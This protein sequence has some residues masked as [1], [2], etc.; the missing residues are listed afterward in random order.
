MRAQTRVA[1][2]SG[3]GGQAATVLWAVRRGWRPSRPSPITSQSPRRSISSTRRHRA[4]RLQRL[5]QGG[6][7]GPAAQAGLQVAEQDDRIGRE[8]RPGDRRRRRLGDEGL[9]DRKGRD[10]LRPRLLPAHRPD[11]REARQL[12]R[13]RRRRRR[14]RRVHRQATDPRRA[15]RLELPLGRHPRHVRSPRLHGLGRDQPGLH[16]G[17]PQRHDALHSHGVR[18]LDRRSAR[19]EDAA[20]AFDAGPQRRRPSG[21]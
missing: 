6:D 9:G 5:Q 8:A 21:S 7:E 15:R 18:L 12:P 13:A 10:A 3:G 16:S 2:R 19:Q 14:G 4:L 11:R 17:E 20:A 1:R